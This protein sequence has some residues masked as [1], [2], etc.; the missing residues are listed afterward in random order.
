MKVLETFPSAMVDPVLLLF[1]V[2]EL[3]T[4]PF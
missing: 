1:P 2:K 3:D 4:A